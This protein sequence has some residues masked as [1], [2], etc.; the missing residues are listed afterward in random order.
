MF[1]INQSRRLKMK[2]VL[3]RV[4]FGVL[5]VFGLFLAGCAS[6]NNLFNPIHAINASGGKVAAVLGSGQ[7]VKIEGVEYQYANRPTVP[8]APQKPAEPRKPSPPA[9]SNPSSEVETKI[10]DG[11]RYTNESFSSR[12]EA[13]RKIDFYSSQGRRTDL[14]P[15]DRSHALR[16]AE[17][18]SR[19]FEFYEGQQRQYDSALAQYQANLPKYQQEL[20]EYEQENATYQAKLP[21]YT[22]TVEAE[23]MSI[24]ARIYADAPSNW[25]RYVQ[26]QVLLNRGK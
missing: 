17:A 12:E 24:Q 8:A 6:L 11:R 18:L 3:S 2:D 1:C 5:A 22:A 23:V 15:L 20:K 26:G 4:I 16:V 25:D 10:G 21:E 13:I 19:S 9:W 7:T 14:S